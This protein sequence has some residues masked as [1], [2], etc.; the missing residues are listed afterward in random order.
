VSI[1]VDLAAGI[2]ELALA[3]PATAL[4]RLQ[5]YVALLVKW[6]RTYNLTAIR[7]PQRMV[8]HHLLDSLAALPHLGLRPG[9][10][11]LD[12]GTGAGLPGLPLAIAR[13]EALVTLVDA[14]QKKASFVQ[15]AVSELAV[16][17]AT[18]LATRAE[19]LPPAARYDVIITRAY[20]SLAAFAAAGRPVLAAGGRLVAMKGRMP[21][22]EIAA[23]PAGVRVRAMPEL[24]VPGLGAQRH[25][26]IIET[27][28][29][30][31]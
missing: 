24:F 7:D 16:A 23:L 22:D 14:S 19:E 26:I 2:G 5:A 28:E 1:A 6:N 21:D 9:T 20:S 27:A 29:W 18:V 8:T 15:Q 11:V 10:R 25:L 30:V 13:P 3:L 17:N 12:L 4:D 31:G